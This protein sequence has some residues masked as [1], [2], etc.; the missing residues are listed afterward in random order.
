MIEPVSL[1]NHFERSARLL[2]ANLDGL[3]HQQ[4]LWMPV[5]DINCINWLAGHLISTRCGIAMR[6]NLTPVWDDATRTVYKFGSGRLT[7]EGSGVLPLERLIADFTKAH[8]DIDVALRALSPDDL[9]LA[10]PDGRFTSRAEHLLYLQFHEAH[11]AGQVMTLREQLGL[12][13]IWP[14]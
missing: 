8:S 11:H 3:T 12:A 5:P 4:S 10:P 7:G 9:A 2:L 14:F 6:L 1:A 13:S